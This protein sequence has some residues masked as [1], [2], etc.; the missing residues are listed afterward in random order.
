MVSKN[1]KLEQQRK[2]FYS[3][4]RKMFN[5]KLG[6]SSMIDNTRRDRSADRLHFETTNLLSNHAKH[7]KKATVTSNHNNED[8][9]FHM[10]KMHESL[11]LDDKDLRPR[12]VKDGSPKKPIFSAQYSA[13]APKRTGI[14]LSSSKLHKNKTD[15]EK[16]TYET[17]NEKSYSPKR[18]LGRYNL[19]EKYKSATHK[20]ECKAHRGHRIPKSGGNSS[21]TPENHPVPKR[22]FSTTGKDF[23]QKEKLL[24]ESLTKKSKISDDKSRSTAIYRNQSAKPQYKAKKFNVENQIFSLKP[25]KVQNKKVSKHKFS[26]KAVKRK[27]IG[28]SENYSEMLKANY[29]LNEDSLITGKSKSHTLPI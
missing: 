3:E 20:L 11:N 9:E 28:L 25:N 7:F 17:Y 21:I 5:N 12:N 15:F 23:G 8:E 19:A 13:M 6:Y 16:E 26:T 10:Q 1:S 4:T 27:E 29:S 24:E 2:K 18:D 22:N 14:D